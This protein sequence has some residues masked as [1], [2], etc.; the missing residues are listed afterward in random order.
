MLRLLC[1]FIFAL[2]AQAAEWTISDWKTAPAVPLPP[3]AF[4]DS[5]IKTADL[6][7]QVSVDGTTLDLSANIW[8]EHSGA[9]LSFHS[10]ALRTYGLAASYVTAD[11]Y[12]KATLDV[13]GTRPFA[14][15]G[16]GKELA[17]AATADSG[18][19][20]VSHDLTLDRTRLTLLISTVSQAT[21]SGAW[22]LSAKLK[23]DSAS[24]A[25]LSAGT[26]LSFR[27]AHFERESE[28]ESLAGLVM[29]PDGKYLAFRRS[30]REGDENDKQSWVELWDVDASKPYHVFG[31]EGGPSGLEFSPDGKSLYYLLNT[32]NGSEVWVMKLASRTSERLLSAVKNMDRFQ[33]SAD[34]KS[35]VYSVSKEKPENKTGYDLFREL[36]DR[37]YT[38][39]DRRELFVADLVASVT[40]PLTTTGKFE[41]DKWSLSPSGKQVV[42]VK[43]EPKQGRPYVRQEFW[44]LS[45]VSGESRKVY[46]RST[47]EAPQNL[48][49]IDENRIAYSAGS[50]DAAPEDTVFHNATQLVAFTL[51]LRT[52]EHKNL[53]GQQDFSL[54]DQGSQPGIVLNP[55]DRN[56]YMYV[57]LGG[58]TQLARSTVDGKSIK[59]RPF[60]SSYDFIDEPAFAANG[61]RAAYVVSDFNSPMAIA[62]LDMAANR[63]RVLFDPN[64]KIVQDWEFGTMEEWNFTNRLGIQIDGWIYKP[65]NFSADKTWPLIVYYYAGVSPRDVRF[66]YTYQFWLANGY[67]VYVL[68]T[69]GAFGRGQ[70]FADYHANDWGT[71]ATQ[72]VIEGTEKVLAAHP[73]LDGSHMGCYG[74]SYGGFITLDLVTK[75]GMF[76]TAI[77]MYGISNITNYFGGG[78]WG[79][80]YSDIAAPG[81]YPWTRKDIFVDKSP[82]YNAD[83]I[84]T[85]LLI[86]HGGIDDNVPWIE[87]DQMFVSLKL[88]GQD[89]VYARFK[90]ETHN[91][92]VK[93]SN[94]VEHRQMML[95]WFDKYLKGQSAAWDARLK[96]YGE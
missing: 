91:I 88:L 90:D 72:D 51:D 94:L 87:S 89:A 67:V 60:K 81:S 84:K 95:E 58:H 47:I 5:T 92:N 66:S 65:A 25:L 16:N 11:S 9:E 14:V 56:L 64:A 31:R 70:E 19:Y 12:T 53:T 78:M 42:L 1:I 68:N 59:Y 37:V 29:S 80:W 85:P 77:D 69:V 49:W 26:D 43:A 20:K 40:R 18:V 57:A 71:E 13:T 79:Y 61:S 41:L 50:H 74:G 35:I 76:T 63:E 34:G 24:T 55:R 15:F 38:Y 30:I 39:N 23:T 3:V 86:L 36:E 75:T 96:A 32:D 62:V 21:D 22:T 73:Y 93:Y 33:V 44:T 83:K 46:D 10:E 4:E 52:G 82:I 27:P 17:K 7:G 6:L 8:R 2:A 45:L 54:L 48:C 28:L